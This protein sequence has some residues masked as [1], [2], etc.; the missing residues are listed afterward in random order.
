MVVDDGNGARTV[1][2]T[3]SFRDGAWMHFPISVPAGGVVTIR[4]DKTNGANATLSGL[5]LGGG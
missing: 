4:V 3:S 5:F 2:L 1:L